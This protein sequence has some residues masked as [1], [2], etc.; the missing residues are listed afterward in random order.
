M[1]EAVECP[2]GSSLAGGCPVPTCSLSHAT[3]L[4]SRDLFPSVEVGKMSYEVALDL[5]P[6]G[7]LV[8]TTGCEVHFQTG[9]Q[10]YA[11]K[12]RSLH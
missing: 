12:V 1:S 10:C 11:L 5:I 3:S 6:S 8:N 2:D 9:S 4:D 7:G